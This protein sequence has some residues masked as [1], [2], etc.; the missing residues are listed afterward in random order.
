MR[1]I[2]PLSYFILEAI[3]FYLLATW[4]GVGTALLILF[5]SIF[6]GALLAAW[7][8][9]SIT[10]ELARGANNPA[11]LA[12]DLGLVGVGTLLLALPG[13]LS[14]I[15]G[16]IFVLP[17]TRLLIRKIV[18]KRVR[19]QIEEMG[20]RSFE[21]ANAY[22]QKASYGSFGDANANN[23]SQSPAAPIIIDE[24]E[25][26][27]WSRDVTPEDFRTNPNDSK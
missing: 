23:T 10:A 27:K 3:T 16:L 1:L 19:V 13:I 26:E 15:I 2:L 5:A 7:Q 22:R 4:L 14:S 17:P 21:A 9:R 25:I 6:G 12:G 20:V 24:E 18:A 11:V 8:M